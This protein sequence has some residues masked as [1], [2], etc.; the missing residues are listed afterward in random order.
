MV[1]KNPRFLGG[2]LSI[3][4]MLKKAWSKIQSSFIRYDHHLTSEMEGD[5]MVLKITKP[6][7]NKDSLGSLTG[8]TCSWIINSLTT[9][10]V[11]N[12]TCLTEHE[13]SRSYQ[14][15]TTGIAAYYQVNSRFRSQLARENHY[16]SRVST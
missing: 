5:K 4:K 6:P 2:Q 3:S 9:R 12:H 10:K 7:R 8:Q 15:S 11:P 14:P 13:A 1:F 16:F